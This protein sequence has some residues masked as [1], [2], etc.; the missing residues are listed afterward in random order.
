MT[1]ALQAIVFDFDGVIVDSERL[2]LRAYQD[3]LTP[4]GL[5]LTEEAYYGEYLG[6]DD[7]GFFRKY[8]RTSGR[9]WDDKA[10]AGLVRTKAQRYEELSGQGQMVFPGAEAFI[11]AAA[12]AVPLA[13]ASGA[14]TREIEDVL[15]RLGLRGLFLAIVG[16]DQT[17]RSKPSP[18]PYLE[19]FGRLGLASRRS[20]DPTHCVAI[21]DS[22]WGLESAR[23]AGLRCVAVATT[24]SVE[25]LEP[26]AELVVS[27]LDELTLVALDRLCE[28]APRLSR[29]VPP[30]SMVP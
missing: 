29:A 1:G 26:Y 13:I 23:A 24:Y 6:Y 21:E 9:V 14:L 19:A 8:A 10:I 11:R 16:A 15:D 7:F 18:E 5:G 25:E 12:D 30:R 20:L 28:S 3:V 22:R 17:L 2:H 27:G 4:L